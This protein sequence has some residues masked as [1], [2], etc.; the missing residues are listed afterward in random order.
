MWRKRNEANLPALAG[1]DEYKKQVPIA[2]AI[3]L[4][5]GVSEGGFAPVLWHPKHK[6]NQVEWSRAVLDGK[7]T[8]AIRI[9]KPSKRYGPYTVL[10]DGESFLRAKE[11]K[12]AHRRKKVCLWTCPPKIT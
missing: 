10:C 2:R 11:S 8:G 7:L 3:P 9:L 6:T 1:K 12:L 4:W 5:G